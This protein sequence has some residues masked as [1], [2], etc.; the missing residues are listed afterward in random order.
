MRH[1]RRAALFSGIGLLAIWL[2]AAASTRPTGEQSTPLAER[3]AVVPSDPVADDLSAQAERLNHRTASVATPR[4]PARNPFEFATHSR[5][6]AAAA[7]SSIPLPALPPPP[8]P[9]PLFTLVAIG[10]T[11]DTRTAIVSAFDQ[12]L[13]LKV[14]DQIMSRFRI[15]AIG[16]DAVE[17]IDTVDN[18]P[19]RLGLR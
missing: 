14:G 7:A 15:A 18:T 12:V 8:A 10:Q 2:A 1:Q 16:A 4:L 5:P 9:K 17:V 13:L 11:G 3:R 6:R 19:I